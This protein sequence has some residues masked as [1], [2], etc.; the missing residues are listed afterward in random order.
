MPEAISWLL[1]IFHEISFFISFNTR[2]SEGKIKWVKCNQKLKTKSLIHENVVLLLL[3]ADY[4]PLSHSVNCQS[5]MYWRQQLAVSKTSCP[6][7]MQLQPHTVW[8]QPAVWSCCAAAP[9][10]PRS[11]IMSDQQR[12][13]RLTKEVVESLSLEMFKKRLHVALR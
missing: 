3:C 13:N 12:Q 9:Q 4:C 10:A 6:C 1:T 11:T 7:R 8:K 2:K 5:L